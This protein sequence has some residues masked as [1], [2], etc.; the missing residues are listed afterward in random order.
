[1]WQ[2]NAIGLVLTLQIGYTKVYR[3]QYQ[4]PKINM[5]EKTH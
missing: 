1:M 3:F 2:F 5:K 4:G